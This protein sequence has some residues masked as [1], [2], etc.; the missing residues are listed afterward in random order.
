[1]AQ[2]VYP[3]TIGNNNGKSKYKVVPCGKCIPCRRRRQAQ[4]SFRLMQEMQRSTSAAFITLTYSDENLPLIDEEVEGY[5]YL[6]GKPTL[7]K[8]DVQ[9]W[10]KKLRKH[11]SKITNAKIKYYGCGEYGTRTK[12][13]HYH[14]IIFNVA[15]ELLF[16]NPISEIWEKGN[17]QVDECNIQ[18]VQYVTKYVM[19]SLGRPF[20]VGQAEFSMMS[21]RLGDNFLTKRRVSHYRNIERPY[22]VWENGQKH[23]MPRYYKEKI[24]HDNPE[25]L[26]K[27]GEDALK[28]VIPQHLNTSKVFEIEQMNLKLKRLQNDKRDK[29]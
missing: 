2:C 29:I 10:M 19:K 17:A 7:S 1:M 16:N 5:E 4:W 13:P 21:K 26:R 18:T 11:Q 23:S 6:L 28:V 24:W 27:F 22:I 15:P 20:K 25:L 9:L 12:R 14:F 8:R 3:I